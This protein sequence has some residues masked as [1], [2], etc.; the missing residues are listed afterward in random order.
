MTRNREALVQY[1]D[2]HSQAPHDFNGNC[3]AC[4]VLGAV[5]AQFGEAPRVDAQ[6]NDKRSAQ[7]AIA[8]LGGFEHAVDQLFDPVPT[9]EAEFGDIAGVI[10][11]DLGFHVMLIEGQ[12]LVSPGEQG[13]VRIPRS[14]MVK[15]WSAA[16]I[17]ERLT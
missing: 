12:T 3:C 14:D 7:R 16:P 17:A 15:A 6:W 13:L 5:S 4:F 11:P 2:A 9:G 8:N 1:I 10:D